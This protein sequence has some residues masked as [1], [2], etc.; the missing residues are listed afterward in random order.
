MSLPPVLVVGGTSDIGRATAAAFAADGHPIVLAG[1]SQDA[2][3]RE[4]KDIAA[5]FRV[6]VDVRLLDVRAPEAFGAFLAS[7]DPLPGIVVSAAGLMGGTNAADVSDARVVVETNFLGPAVL[8]GTFAEA[9]RARGSGTLVGISSVAGDRGRAKTM[10]YGAAKAGFTA[11]LSALR[12]Q[13]HGSG[14]T[15]LTVRPGFVRTRMTQGLDLPPVLTANPNRVA[16]DI[17]RAVRRR[18]SHLVTPP[19]FIPLMAVI[20]A[21]PEALFKRL[22]F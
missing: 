7:L 8:L 3:E 6:P 9:F 21:L 12:Q 1:R 13:L 15:V 11:F 4:A 2:L 16:R 19:V 5:R 18:R 17:R 14:V 10:T 22:S 20:R